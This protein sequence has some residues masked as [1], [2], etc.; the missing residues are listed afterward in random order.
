MRLNHREIKVEKTTVDSGLINNILLTIGTR[1]PKLRQNNQTSGRSLHNSLKS[2][3][4]HF[5]LLK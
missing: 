4:Y 1:H 2:G 5:N 3:C